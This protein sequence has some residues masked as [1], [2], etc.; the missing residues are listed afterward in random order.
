MVYDVMIQYL[1]RIIPFLKILILF[2]YYLFYLFILAAPGLSCRI[3]VAACELLSC[4]TQD[5]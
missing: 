1:Y 3:F 2:I 4:G 5:L